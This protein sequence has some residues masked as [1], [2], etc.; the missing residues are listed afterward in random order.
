MEAQASCDGGDCS[1]LFYFVIPGL[2]MAKGVALTEREG[3]FQGWFPPRLDGFVSR[4]VLASPHPVY[5]LIF[6]LGVRSCEGNFSTHL[7][8]QPILGCSTGPQ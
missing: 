6:L 8:P 3:L 2:V 5:P 4:L 1:G 7:W